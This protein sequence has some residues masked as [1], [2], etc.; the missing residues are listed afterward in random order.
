MQLKLKKCAGY[1]GIEHDAYIYKN[2]GGKKYCKSC[3][4]KLQKPKPIKKR[5][6]KQVFKMTLK[7]EQ[8]QEDIKFYL[9]VWYD[10][11]GRVTGTAMEG[12]VDNV[13]V[14]PKCECCGKRLF[15]EPN[16]TY[17]HHIL[18]K[19]NYPNLRHYKPNIAIICTDCHSNYES[20]PDNVPYL[21]MLKEELISQVEFMGT[22]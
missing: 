2:I 20:N 14:V 5:T 10:R 12:G 9:D 11:F 3:A 21:K 8:V 4:F 1:D 22:L 16:L 18:E 15:W 17:F 6:E 13:Q 7:K 19:R